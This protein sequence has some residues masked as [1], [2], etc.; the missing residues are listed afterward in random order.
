MPLTNLR[1]G[2]EELDFFVPTASGKY[3]GPTMKLF[4]QLVPK[5]ELKDYAQGRKLRRVE[6]SPDFC[7]GP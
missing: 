6:R 2:S 5:A 3:E 4:L 7:S 1:A